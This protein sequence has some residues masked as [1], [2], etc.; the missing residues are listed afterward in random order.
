[1]NH[2]IAAVFAIGSSVVTDDDSAMSDVSS[3]IELDTHANMPVVG[4]NAFIIRDSGRIANVTPYSPEYEAQSLP[5]VDAIVL[6]Q[7]SVYGKE[8]LLLIRNA[9]YVPTMV[10]NLVPPFI[11]REQGIQVRDIAKIH[12]KDPG[13][14]DHAI[15]FDAVLRIPLQLHGIFSYFPVRKPTKEEVNTVEDVYM[16]TPDDFHPHDPAYAINEANMVDW[17]GDIVPEFHR[18]R[19]IL[20]DIPEPPMEIASVTCISDEEQQHIDKLLSLCDS[21]TSATFHSEA[22]TISA[23]FCQS[24]LC[25]RLEERAEI[26]H[27]MC[28]L[29]A[30]YAHESA[31]LLEHGEEDEME[32]T[33]DEFDLQEV[34]ADDLLEQLLDRIC[35]GEVHLNDIQADDLRT[36][37]VSSTYAKP[38][39]GLDAQLLSK[40]WKIDLPMA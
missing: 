27:M 26:S 18:Q 1:M 17:K 38:R 19:V 7:D 5:I 15:V 8:F 23:T 12:V 33:I 28:S 6:Y 9:L 34:D 21:H 40:V 10:H 24:T 31:W 22:A 13:D 37:G 30:T 20:E 11:M 35:N 2:K 14:D 16:L 4:M 39:E 25:E 36:G 32:S 29:G 3:R